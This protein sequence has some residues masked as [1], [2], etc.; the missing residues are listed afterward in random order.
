MQRRLLLVVFIA[1]LTGCLEPGSTPLGPEVIEQDIPED[2]RIWR[3]A[4]ADSLG[5]AVTA[6]E[7]PIALYE[8][9]MLFIGYDPPTG[10]R[11][12]ALWCFDL[13]G[14]ED[15]AADLTQVYLGLSFAD[16]DAVHVQ[17]D[18]NPDLGRDVLV[19]L[20]HLPGP[21]DTATPLTCP[22]DL[23]DAV[24]VPL[25]RGDG[26]LDY[27]PFILETPAGEGFRL[28][29][30]FLADWIAAGDTLCLAMEIAGGET[31]MIRV[32]ARGSELEEGQSEAVL[33]IRYDDGTGGEAG[34]S[35]DCWL[36]AQVLDRQSPEDLTGRLVLATGLPRVCHVDLG[37]LDSFPRFLPGWEEGR[38][39][40]VIRGRLYFAADSSSLFGMSPRDRNDNQSAGLPASEGGLT[41]NLYA[42]DEDGPQPPGEVDGILL[43]SWIDIF[44][45]HPYADSILR[46]ELRDPLPLPLT[47]WLQN[48]AAGE[49][50]D[51]GLILYLDG[52]EDRPRSLEYLVDT[53]DPADRPRLEIFYTWRP[54]YE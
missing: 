10:F 16:P 2:V 11:G 40:M 48:V 35:R 7:E 5:L 23:D 26:T 29:E 27:E 39:L 25:R 51:H 3:L 53:A 42:S 4:G 30:D 14:W 31:G 37:C 47:S 22:L 43:D 54:D 17:D 49:D 18:D 41:L 9:E 21:P 8:P 33:K 19:R 32:I 13:S 44:R 20:W 52:R 1:L 6:W 24:Q 28:P 50:E 15:L 34:A 36:D 38:Q 45:E 46:V 12:E